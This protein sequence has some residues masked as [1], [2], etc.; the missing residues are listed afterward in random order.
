MRITFFDKTEL[1]NLLKER[2]AALIL[3]K[4]AST[5]ARINVWDLLDQIQG[6][7]LVITWGKQ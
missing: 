2:K 5:I 1:E 3:D 6:E 7:L 4:P